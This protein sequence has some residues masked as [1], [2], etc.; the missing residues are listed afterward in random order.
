M[1]WAEQHGQLPKGTAMTWAHHTPDI[2]ALPEQVEKTAEGGKI[3]RGLMRD[4]LPALLAGTVGAGYGAYQAPGGSP[5]RGALIGGMGGLGLGGGMAAGNAFLESPISRNIESGGVRSAIPLAAG[6]AGLSAG[7]LGGRDLAQSARLGDLKDRVSDDLQEIDPASR[8]FAMLPESLQ[9]YLPHVHSRS[10]R[11]DS[12]ENVCA[13]QTPARVKIPAYLN[14]EIDPKVADAVNR[15]CGK[16]QGKRADEYSQPLTYSEAIRLAGAGAVLSAAIPPA[17]LGGSAI[18]GAMTAPAGHVMHGAGSAVSQTM[19]T[20]GGGLVGTGLGAVGGR[21]LAGALGTDPS[22]GASGGA[23]VGAG[24]GALAGNYVTRNVHPGP[25]QLGLGQKHEKQGALGS[26]K[27]YEKQYPWTLQLC[28]SKSVISRPT[29][30]RPVSGMESQPNTKPK[31]TPTTE[32]AS[33]AVKIPAKDVESKPIP[34]TARCFG[35]VGE[36]IQCEM[37]RTEK[38]GLPNNARATMTAANTAMKV[39]EESKPTQMVNEHSSPTIGHELQKWS[40][41]QAWA[42]GCKAVAIDAETREALGRVLSNRHP[43]G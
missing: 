41:L 13:I 43:A 8:G 14:H 6:A 20:A 18:Y 37:P 30:G 4:L 35:E 27:D 16:G 22:Y 7:L 19:G 32:P 26:K 11:A 42:R 33:K 39:L 29:I 25:K 12:T 2:K 40:A 34:K 5:A 17:L 23:L 1:F 36:R 38:G 21:M 10:K 31:K 24:L 28:G 15:I 3:E 9:G